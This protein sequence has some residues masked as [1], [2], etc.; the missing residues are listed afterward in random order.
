MNKNT[1]ILFCAF[2]FALNGCANVKNSLGLEKSSPDEFAVLTR[3]PLEIP[4]HLQLP[5]PVPGQPRPQ[6]Q[7]TIDQAQQ[8]VF[9]NV[10]QKGT[11]ASS[12][13]AVL[14][15]KAGADSRLPN[16]RAAV[17]N[18]TKELEYRNVPAAKKILN[19]GSKG[20]PSATV[21]DAKKEL[22][23]L[24]ANKEAGKTVTEGETPSIEE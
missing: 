19:L 11:Q 10:P 2:V 17:N 23:R 22:E 20:Q 5:Q 16:I 24:K 6:E 14:L 12:A 15:D 13:E 8:A 9:G 18:E 1:L 4:P 7:S 3:A 21:V